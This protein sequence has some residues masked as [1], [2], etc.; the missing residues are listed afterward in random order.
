M[1]PVAEEIEGFAFVDLAHEGEREQEGGDEEEDVHAAGDFADPDM[2]EHHEEHSEGAQALDFGAESSRFDEFFEGVVVG[3]ACFDGAQRRGTGALRGGGLRGSGGF[4]H[5]WFLRAGR[6]CVG[7]SPLD[8][9][10]HSY[11]KIL[12]RTSAMRLVRTRIFLSP[13]PDSNR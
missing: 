3:F 8:T 1:H 10:G 4:R 2:V 7:A 6:R 12:I 5:T 11:N 13:L 9:T